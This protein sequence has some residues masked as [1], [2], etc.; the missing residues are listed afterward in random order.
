MKYTLTLS[1]ADQ[2]DACFCLGDSV[3][4]YK[5]KYK[6]KYKKFCLMEWCNY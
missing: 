3:D 6:N 5:N 2:V 1:A 4:K